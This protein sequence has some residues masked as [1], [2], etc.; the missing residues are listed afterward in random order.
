MVIRRLN[1]HPATIV[2][3]DGTYVKGNTL[4]MYLS[5]GFRD[6]LRRWQLIKAVKV[7]ALVA[8]RKAKLISHE[9]MKYASL[10]LIGRNEHIRHKMEIKV[11]LHKNHD[12]ETFILE[13]MAAGDLILMAT[14]APGFYV[15]WLWQG[16]LVASSDN[17]PD[18]K[19][20]AKLKAVSNWLAAKNATP[21][22][23]L[24]DHHDDLPLGSVAD[25]VI[26]VNPSDA[27]VKAFDKAE[28]HYSTIRN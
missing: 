9:K 8:A 13:R 10:G 27:T 12:V 23:L 16:A 15:K 6:L 14:A 22:Y 11:A 7:V 3:L 26:L 17:G 19:G 21:S 24:T 25:N 4:K 28:I 20:E 5:I 18:C 1:S 2:D